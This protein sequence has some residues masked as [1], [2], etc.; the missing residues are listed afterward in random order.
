MDVKLQKREIIKISQKEI[1]KLINQLADKIKDANVAYDYIV[2]IAR[3]GIHISKPLSKILKVPHKSIRVSFYSTAAH[4]YPIMI[5][6]KSIDKLDNHKLLF[7]DDLIDA[8]HTINW[9]NE[10]IKYYY[11]YDVG[12]LYHNK[13][14]RYAVTPTYYATEKPQDWLIFPWD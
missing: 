4:Q 5:N 11:T 7:I 14:N 1:N 3:G 8:G 12:V 6:L 9:L 10:N 13:N 2:G